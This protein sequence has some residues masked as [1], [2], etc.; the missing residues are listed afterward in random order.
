MVVEEAQ[1]LVTRSRSEIGGQ[2]SGDVDLR[3]I[4]EVEWMI[5]YKGSAKEEKEHVQGLHRRGGA[6]GVLR[7]VQRRSH[8]QD[9]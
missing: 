2:E 8:Q 5:E 7:S 9:S 6:S 3:G 4:G 1:G